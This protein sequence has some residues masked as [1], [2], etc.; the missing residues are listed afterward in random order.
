VRKPSIYEYDAF[1]PYLTAQLEWLKASD[2]RLSLRWLAKRLEMRSH[3]HLLRIASGDKRPTEELLAKLAPLFE[4]SVDELAFAKAL[5]GLAGAES[6]GERAFYKDKLGELK[7]EGESVLLAIDAFESIAHWH[8]LAIFEMTALPGFCSDP[9]WI[10]A[11]LGGDVTPDVAQESIERLVRL[12][13]LRRTED[14]GIE[15]VISTFQTSNNVPSAAI[16]RFHAEHLDRAK[17][18]LEAVPVPLRLFFGQTLPLNRAR[19]AEAQDLIVEFRSRFHK[20]MSGSEPDAVYH[21][22]IQL[23]PVASLRPPTA[24]GPR[25]DL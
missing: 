2:A 13:L 12:G 19:L 9:E 25:G 5:V 16:R 6:P 18:A 14:G 20:I 11:R 1:G 17:A 22:G 7:V 3:T 24:E 23:V 8:H 15:R 21:L 4:L 10:A